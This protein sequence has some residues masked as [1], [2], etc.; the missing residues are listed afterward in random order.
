MNVQRSR[1]VPK[2]YELPN[3]CSNAQGKSSFVCLISY[4]TQL[5]VVG[6]MLDTAGKIICTISPKPNGGVF[7]AAGWIHSGDPGMN[8]PITRCR[9]KQTVCNVKRESRSS[10]CNRPRPARSR[11]SRTFMMG[12]YRSDPE[13]RQLYRAC[14]SLLLQLGGVWPG[15][16]H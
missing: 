14:L 1:N 5:T 2:N 6:F 12:M 15:R 16:S 7:N 11:T 13:A 4:L 8:S 10:G 9:K 3:I